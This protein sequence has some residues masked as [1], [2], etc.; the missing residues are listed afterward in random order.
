MKQY[1]HLARY[2][3]VCGGRT[4][5][6]GTR[7]EPKHIVGYGSVND[8]AK[9]FDLT[10]DQVVECY[11]YHINS[12]PG[13]KKDAVALKRDWQAVGNTFKSVLGLK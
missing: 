12:Q 8:T 11:H 2:E 3:N 1:K 13:V 5:I 7:I 6:K 4:V 9:Y 10:R